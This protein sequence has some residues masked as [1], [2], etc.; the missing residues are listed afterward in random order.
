MLIAAALLIAAGAPGV[1]DYYVLSM[2]WSPE[3]CAS[4]AGASDNTQCAG[5]RKF[6]FIIHGLWPQFERRGPQNCAQ[7]APP[8][9]IIDQML[10]LMPSERLIRHQWSKHG[11][12]SGLTPASYFTAT[13]RAF[14]SVSQPPRF[15]NPTSQ[16]MVAP[17]KARQ[18]ILAANPQLSPGAI[19]LQCRGRFFQE[20]RVCFDKNLKPRPCG[21]DVR[22]TCRADEMIVRPL[23]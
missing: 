4:P 10:P 7:S 21:R 15:K 1:L 22:D 5:L 11:T 14:D 16:V 23:R 2:S 19:A 18:E 17:A 12:C 9:A 13:R 20:L 8:R 6:G 3:H